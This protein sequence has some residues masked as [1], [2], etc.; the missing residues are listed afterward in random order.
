MASREEKK[1][2]TRRKLLD[3]A[4][5]LVAKQGA[6][7][8]SLD[9][10]AEKAGLTKGAIY[11]NFGSKEELLFAVADEAQVPVIAFEDFFNPKQTLAENFERL[12]E[13]LAKTFSAMSP[14][15]WQLLLEIVHFAMR[16]QKAR[17]ALA[18]E[19]RQSREDAAQFFR[20]FATETGETLPLPGDELNIAL[21][22][23]SWG[24]LQLRAMD[25]KSVPDE[26]FPKLFR[27]LAAGASGNS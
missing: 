23:L 26:L 18:A 19:Q 7:A 13:Y 22:A 11:S 21:E 27:L 12:G 14:R 4:A 1:A 17:R 20:G 5:T 15:S 3:A 6:L 9:E 25:P 2:Q 10:I 8:T 24:L 16:N